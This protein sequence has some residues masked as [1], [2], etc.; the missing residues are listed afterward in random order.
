M[1]RCRMVRKRLASVDP[2]FLV[3]DARLDT[4]A[5]VIE[6]HWPEEIAADGLHD[7]ALMAAV[8][9]ARAALLEALGLAELV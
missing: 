4:I 6:A 2:R 9:A 8:E 7:P 1:S 5:A 3:D